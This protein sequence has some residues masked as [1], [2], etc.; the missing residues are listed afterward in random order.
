MIVHN[1]ENAL[2]NIS[3]WPNQKHIC[4]FSLEVWVPSIYLFVYLLLIL[5]LT[6]GSL[7]IPVMYLLPL[8]FGAVPVRFSLPWN[9]NSPSPSPPLSPVCNTMPFKIFASLISTRIHF[10]WWIDVAYWHEDFPSL[11]ALYVI[12]TACVGWH[13]LWCCR[14]S[15]WC[16]K[17]S[18][19]AVMPWSLGRWFFIAAGGVRAVGVGGNRRRK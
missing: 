13:L 2:V 16:G 15:V 11:P 6:E 1:P 8:L 3:V 17:A 4:L 10:D 14:R 5:S 9:C 7:L 19:S 12:E 18:H